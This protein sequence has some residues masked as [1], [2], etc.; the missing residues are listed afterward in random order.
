MLLHD[1]YIRE[2]KGSLH[3]GTGFLLFLVISRCAHN[4]IDNYTN[5]R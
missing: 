2:Y 1:F 4:G 3:E 5:I